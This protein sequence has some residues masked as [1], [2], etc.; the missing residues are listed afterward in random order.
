[1][2]ALFI[3]QL[4]V[5]LHV[6]K[7]FGKDITTDHVELNQDSNGTSL[8]NNTQSL[9]YYAI[10]ATAWKY[11]IIYDTTSVSFLLKISYAYNY[12]KD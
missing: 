11:V 4:S 3:T 12:S 10:K 8:E 1:M 7:N 6:S 5:M 2:Y 9:I